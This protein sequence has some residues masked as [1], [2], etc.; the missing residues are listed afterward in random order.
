MAAQP[1]KQEK[2]MV[3]AVEAKDGHSD[4]SCRSSRPSHPHHDEKVA[5]YLRECESFL[6]TVALRTTTPDPVRHKEEAEAAIANVEN[7][8]NRG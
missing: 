2:K 1:T 4:S 8:L 7:I 5:E 3:N 6:T